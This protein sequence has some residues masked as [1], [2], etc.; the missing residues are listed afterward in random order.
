M[1]KQTFTLG[2]GMSYNKIKFFVL[3]K[4]AADLVILHK[5]GLDDYTSCSKL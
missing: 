3:S 5:A 4:T 1:Q 2:I